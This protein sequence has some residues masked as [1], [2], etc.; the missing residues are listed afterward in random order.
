MLHRTRNFL[1]VSLIAA[2]IW[3]FAEAES[4]RPAEAQPECYFAPQP[5]SDRTIDIIEAGENGANRVRARVDLVGS[6]LAIDA[7]ERIFRKPLTFSPGMD[8]VPKEPGEHTINLLEAIRQHPELRN[9]GV[10]IKR[11]EPSSV[12]VFIDQ[13]ISMSVQVSVNVP[14]D[15][16]EG[17]SE[18]KP[19]VVTLTLPR[20]EAA[21]LTPQSTAIARVEPASLA[22]LTPGRRQSLAGVAVQLPAEIADSNHARLDPVRVEVLLTPR[23]QSRSIRIASVPI[24]LRV[25]PGEFG[26]WDID[27]PE[28]DRFLTDVT[29]TGP[30]PAIKQIE[31]RVTPLIATLPLSFEEL[32]T[33]ISSKE[34]VFA[35][36]P[37]GARAEVANRTVRLRITRRQPPQPEQ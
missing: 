7:A 22:S 9:R 25:A 28:Q 32:E 26:K 3:V 30:G 2:L 37:A 1:G 16:T 20:S 10:T 35:D 17:V 5:G 34:A 15:L 24:H 23:S 6:T 12:K 27:I 36:L 21:L 29:I 4:L 8:G 14:T 13:L 18:V 33:G 19:A 11:V 31:D